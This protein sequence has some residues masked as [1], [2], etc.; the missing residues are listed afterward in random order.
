MKLFHKRLLIFFS[1]ALNVGFLIMAIVMMLHS[2]DAS[3]HRSY[4]E[5]L[6][7]VKQLNLA[8]DQELALVETIKQFRT[9]LDQHNQDLKKARSAIV[10]LLAAAGPVDRNQLRRLTAAVGSEENLKN[11]A[12][13]AHFMDIRSQLGHEKGAQFFTLLLARI[14]ARD[15]THHR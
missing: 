10:R 12:F 7:I 6:D 14:E 9:T 4:Q 3:H 8:G 1:V 15:Q 2:T 13:E 5:I 11:E